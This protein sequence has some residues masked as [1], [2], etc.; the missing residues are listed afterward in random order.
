MSNV[1][2]ESKST[3]IPLTLV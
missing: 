1:K 2:R 3:G